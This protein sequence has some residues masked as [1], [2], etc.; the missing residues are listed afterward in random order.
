[1]LD[2]TASSTTNDFMS[3]VH[4]ASIHEADS[5]V[6]AQKLPSKGDSPRPD[7]KPRSRNRGLRENGILPGVAKAPSRNLVTGKLSTKESSVEVSVKLGKQ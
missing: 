2:N 4:H 1:M 7:D 3:S 5:E 6:Q